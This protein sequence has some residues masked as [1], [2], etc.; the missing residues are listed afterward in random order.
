MNSAPQGGQAAPGAQGQYAYYCTSPAGYYPQ[1]QTCAK[2]W[3]KVVPE[4]SPP[5]P[6]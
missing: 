5:Q 2:G 1:V 4:S 3:L 6:R